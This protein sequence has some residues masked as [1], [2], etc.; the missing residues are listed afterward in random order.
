MTSAGV[1]AAIADERPSGGLFITF[2]GGDGVGKTTQ[3]ALLDTWLSERGRTVLR[4]REPGGTEVGVLI[5]DIVLHHRGDIAPR[6][7][8][9]LYAADRAHH[10]ETVVRP[11]LGRGEVV[12]QDRYLD[13]SVAYQGEGRQLEPA[14]IREL[15]LWAA[16]GLLPDLTVLL[17][18]DH[19]AARRRLDADD[20]P[21]DR[22]EAEREDFHDRVRDRFLAIAREEPGRFLVLDASRPPANLAAAVRDRVEVLLA[23]I[24]GAQGSVGA[25]G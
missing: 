24:P 7:E 3:A 15:S 4:T 21:F 8:A 10:I 25:R 14:Q 5:R 1:P 19:G 20:K 6:A 23:G 2:E 22:L 18:L 17:D 16:G 13:S 12:I 11:A 9:L